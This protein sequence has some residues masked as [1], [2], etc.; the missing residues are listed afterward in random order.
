MPAYCSVLTQRYESIIPLKQANC[1][2]QCRNGTVKKS[3]PK[4]TMILTE[5]SHHKVNLTAAQELSII[6]HD[7]Q[8]IGVF[9]ELNFQLS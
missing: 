2:L 7:V 5:Q 4:K 6:L 3:G 8:Q 9:M 1:V